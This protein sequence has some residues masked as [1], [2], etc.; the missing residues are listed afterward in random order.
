VPIYALGDLV[1][2]IASSAFV[3]PDAIII[4]DVVL[5]D[6]VSIWAGAVLR[7][8]MGGI[9][10]GARSNV[11]DN[12]VIHATDTYDTVIGAGVVIGHLAHLEGCVVNDGA[13]VGSGSIVLHRAVIG[14]G[15][16]V[17]AG[18]VVPN[19]MD[20]P[21]GRMA[22]GVPATIKGP[23]VPGGMIANNAARYVANGQ[24]YRH[25]LRRIG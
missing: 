19:D 12:A 9:R 15:A 16:L 25:E 13:L 23:E 22:L 3:H 18:A 8:D 1:P 4:G 24:R 10:V 11:Q 7:G 5:G 17:G 2:A 20:V 21:P 6:E 14:A